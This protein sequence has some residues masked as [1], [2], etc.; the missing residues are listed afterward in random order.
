V[1][2]EHSLARYRQV[3]RTLHS[4][5]AY[6]DYGENDDLIVCSQPFGIASSV[7]MTRVLKSSG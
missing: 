4:G 3:C 5:G 1:L 6:I 2:E 7:S